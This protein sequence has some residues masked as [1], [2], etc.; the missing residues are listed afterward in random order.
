MAVVRIEV[1][2]LMINY[3]VASVVVFIPFLV[4]ATIPRTFNLS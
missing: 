3:V 2:L 1:I 4:G